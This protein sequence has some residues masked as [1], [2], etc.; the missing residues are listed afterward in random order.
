FFALS[1]P[2][3]HLLA[4]LF[5]NYLAELRSPCG[6][7][8]IQSTFTFPANICSIVYAERRST[9]RILA[10]WF[11]ELSALTAEINPSHGFTYLLSDY[12]FLRDEDRT[13]G[14]S[15]IY[16]QKQQQKSLHEIFYYR[17]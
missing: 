2:K 5:H 11:A 7:S 1:S 16:Y 17:R 10:A 3:L 12:V 13:S 14:T 9:V 6:S 15:S 4:K 8:P